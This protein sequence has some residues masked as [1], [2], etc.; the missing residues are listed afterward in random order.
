MCCYFPLPV[1]STSPPWQIAWKPCI[2]DRLRITV[3]SLTKNDPTAEQTSIMMEWVIEG[4]SRNV[5][6]SA[7]LRREE[8]V[9]VSLYRDEQK[10]VG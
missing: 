4:V 10:A 9:H 2:A 6:S 5:I 1:P 3:T 8:I 7:V